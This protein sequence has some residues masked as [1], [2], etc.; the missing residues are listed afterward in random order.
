M[1]KMSRRILGVHEAVGF[2]T[3]QNRIFWLPKW[4]K[5]T[6]WLPLID[7]TL[8]INS[9][10]SFRQ[11]TIQIQSIDHPVSVS[12]PSR[13][14]SR[15]RPVSVKD[16]QV[17]V[18]SFL[19]QN[20]QFTSKDRPDLVNRYKSHLQPA[21]MQKILRTHERMFHDSGKFVLFGII[22]KKIVTLY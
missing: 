1:Q 18:K 3:R 13:F 17:S 10:S 8:S 12:R 16:H 9:P 4:W 15:E 5:S 11:L 6:G 19:Q 20:V 2:R 7:I 22:L 21:E 14:P